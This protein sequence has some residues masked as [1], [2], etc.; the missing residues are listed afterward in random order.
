M[1]H[2]NEFKLMDIKALRQ[3]QMG[4]AYRASATLQIVRYL[5]KQQEVLNAI[6][7]G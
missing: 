2:Q 5:E 3:S 7:N 6:C 4:I 1:L